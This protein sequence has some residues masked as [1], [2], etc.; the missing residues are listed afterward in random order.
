VEFLTLYLFKHHPILAVHRIRK[1][2]IMAESDINKS[3]PDKEVDN[4]D[5][6]VNYP[7]QGQGRTNGDTQAEI[8]RLNNF[9]N[10]LAGKF[11]RPNRNP[12]NTPT[13]TPSY[14]APLTPTPTSTATVSA[15]PTPTVTAS[16]TPTV[17]LSVTP[18]ATST[19]TPTASATPTVT[20]SV[21]P[22]VT[23]TITPT[24]TSTA[25][26]TPT[27]TPT[28]TPTV[29]ASS[30]PTV[31]PTKTST[32]TPTGTP[33]ATPT[34]TFAAFDTFLYID[35]GTN[36]ISGNGVTLSGASGSSISFNE[37][38]TIN[39]PLS[40]IDIRIYIGGVYSYRITTY[41][42]VITQNKAFILTTDT[43]AIYTSSFGAGTDFGS[44]RRINF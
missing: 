43:G 23:A 35:S 27:A 9:T 33:T 5:L 29:T 8:D 7:F 15:T 30:T 42:E 31:T 39:N 6:F 16:V 17:T 34:P 20:A 36:S 18:T 25:T 28:A 13:P 41:S 11:F 37:I 12:V 19:V 24:T 10:L 22:T 21:T 14:G 40:F 44:Y 2:L 3:K 32:A 4:S 26:P 38:V 1:L